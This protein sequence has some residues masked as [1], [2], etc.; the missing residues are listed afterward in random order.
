MGGAKNRKFPHFLPSDSIPTSYNLDNNPFPHPIGL[1]SWP[2]KEVEEEAV[3]GKTGCPDFLEYASLLF[4]M[5]ISCG[6]DHCPPP[7]LQPNTGCH[8]VSQSHI[9]A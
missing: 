2:H 3:G 6:Q 8:H 9:K 4:G 7:P 1:G 5:K